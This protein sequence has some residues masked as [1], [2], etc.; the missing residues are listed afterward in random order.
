MTM[1]SKKRHLTAPMSLLCA[2][3]LGMALGGTAR[4]EP[5]NVYA[6]PREF[7]G[8]PPLTLGA[9]AP[10]LPHV[11]WIQG[12]AVSRFQ[13]GRV[14]LVEFFATWCQ[15]CRKSVPELKALQARHAPRGLTV[16]GVAAAEQAG[17]KELTTFVKAQ[18][19]NYP[20]AFSEQADVFERW[21]RAGR[22]SGLPWVF[23]VDKK[24]RVAWWGQPFDEGFEGA[25][26]AVL[27]GRAPSLTD[28]QRAQRQA[29]DQEG[30]D[31]QDAMQTA[32]QTGHESQALALIDRLLTIDPER[33]WYE[34][35]LKFELLLRGGDPGAR[36]YGE[37]LVSSV[38][39]NNPHALFMIGK[40]L[41][42]GAPVSPRDL[43]LAER[44]LARAMTLT[45]AESPEILRLLAQVK[46]MQGDRAGAVQLIEKARPWVAPEQRA[47]LDAEIRRY[48]KK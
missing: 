8:I 37:F 12:P 48:Q 27:A 39:R 44:A 26:E 30:W 35:A 24:G 21:M 22:A 20:V 40:A 1:T 41:M 16:V 38:S 34:A 33:F 17:A 31:V 18:R 6:N 28:A 4:A 45:H 9:A 23:L 5:P 13:A 7:E 42:A 25:L 10:P 2:L 29:R 36:D 47:D 43:A 15:P 14:Y 3:G 32:L 11:E 19:L 46:A